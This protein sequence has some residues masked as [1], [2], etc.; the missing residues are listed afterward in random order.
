ML[1]LQLGQNLSEIEKEA[2]QIFHIDDEPAEPAESAPSS[3]AFDV[4][5]ILQRGNCV[6]LEDLTSEHKI[7]R[8]SDLSSDSES[9]TVALS[10]FSLCQQVEGYLNTH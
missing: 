5:S 8:E 4:I 9:E 10:H 7:H 6:C 3:D 1:K 2:V